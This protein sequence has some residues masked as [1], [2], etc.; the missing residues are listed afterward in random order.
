MADLS[1]IR[2]DLKRSRPYTPGKTVSHDTVLRLANELAIKTSGDCEYFIEMFETI[3][4][5]SG[6][7]IESVATA[8]FEIFISYMTDEAKPPVPIRYAS[9]CP[10][11]L[12]DRGAAKNAVLRF[13]I[14]E[15]QWPEGTTIA[16]GRDFELNFE[17]NGLYV[18][19]MQNGEF[20]VPYYDKAIQEHV[21]GKEVVVTKGHR[22]DFKI[23]KPSPETEKV[24]EKLSSHELEDMIETDDED[25]ET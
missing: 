18:I 1:D 21:E 10:I 2:D 6:S 4:S 19:N 11:V 5:F 22:F 7:S 3:A 15:C 20:L 14:L 23:V 24:L 13:A 12:K 16:D 9:F 17:D 25:D 8:F